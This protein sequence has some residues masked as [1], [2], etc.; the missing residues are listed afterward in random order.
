MRKGFSVA[1]LATY[2]AT[3]PRY[4]PATK[5]IINIPIAA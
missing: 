4:T 1:W 3:S 5:L 2:Y